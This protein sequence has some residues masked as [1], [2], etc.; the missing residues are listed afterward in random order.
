MRMRNKLSYFL[1][2]LFIT[3]SVH[4]SAQVT[5]WGLTSKGGDNDVGT[6]YFT[7][8]EGTHNTV[9]H[10]FS[11]GEGDSPV[12][13]LTLGT[14][15]QLYGT[16]PGANID[17]GVIFQIDPHNF[18]YQ[19]MYSFSGGNKGMYP[20]GF[21]LAHANGNIYGMTRNGGEDQS[22][23]I[24]EYTPGD[25]D[26]IIKKHFTGDDGAHPE[27]GLLLANNGL[28]YGVTSYG[29]EN[30]SGV[31]FSFDPATEDYEKLFDF[32]PLS[33]AI[34]VCSLLQASNG[35]LYG[36]TPKGG[37]SNA[38]VLFEYDIISET[39]TKLV[40]FDGINTGSE[41]VGS[42]TETADGLLY[43]IT[44]QNE[45]AETNTHGTIFSYDI[46]NYRLN[47]LYVFD[48]TG[49]SSPTGSLLQVDDYRL[50]GVT[51]KGG[52][53]NDGVRFEYNIESNNFTKKND[54]NG[55]NGSMPVYSK[56]L[57]VVNVGI[58]DK[59]VN[60]NI[61]VYPN[62]AS[63]KLNIRIKNGKTNRINYAVADLLGKKVL[64]G[65]LYGTG[66]FILDMEALSSGTYLLHVSVGNATLTKK[67]TV[68]N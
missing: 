67:I 18:Q 33:G 54:F 39:Y 15:D 26:I 17:Y 66:T 64:E 27:G 52:L 43:G 24:F 45:I 1:L 22:G 51:D 6:V 35:K 5:Y 14:D 37:T 32:G 41:P 46:I 19:K 55:N 57:K 68:R 34:P 60:L 7:D 4:L 30:N 42:L 12:G 38:G 49:G 65:T 13:M 48:G 44:K 58:E 40:D 29:G 8:E 50:I 10:S 56:L 59:I 25:T 2:G 62:P 53:T 16:T 11:Y 21:L 23:T 63:D 28:L 61:S 3:I 47:R 36:V 31:I 9:I 20:T